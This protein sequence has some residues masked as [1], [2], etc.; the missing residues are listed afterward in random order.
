MSAAWRGFRCFGRLV[1]RRPDGDQRLPVLFVK[2]ISTTARTE[3]LSDNLLL[4]FSNKT[5]PL[6]GT[7]ASERNDSTGR[8]NPLAIVMPWMVAKDAHL[9]RYRKLYLDLG[10]DVLT[11]RTHLIQLA[12]PTRGGQVVAQAVLD[13][14]EN[15]P[16]YDRLTL[17]AF[18]LGGY[19]LGEILVRIRKTGDK[20]ADLLPRF[21]AQVYD[22]LVDYTGVATGFSIV[23]AKN[24]YLRK[25]LKTLF[26][27]QALAMYPI[28][29]VHHKACSIAVYDNLIRCPALVINSKLDEVC[30]IEDTTRLVDTWRQKGTD[31]TIRTF[32]DSKHVQ[33][34][35]KYPDRYTDDLVRLLR[36]VELIP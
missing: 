11:V 36:K 21:K 4:Q 31:V 15:R 13:F 12:F 34:I 16:N 24:P 28:S 19:Q 8:N 14:L 7:V 32:D 5:P 17:H 33:H 6:A 2:G 9:E 29:T 1:A 30:S 3:V 25:I 27:V 35:S 20:Y 26:H 18:S 22:S 10:F 23:L